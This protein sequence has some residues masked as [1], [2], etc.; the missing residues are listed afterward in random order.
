M[1]IHPRTLIKKCLKKK[2]TKTIIKNRKTTKIGHFLGGP[3]GSNERGLRDIFSLWTPLW[4]KMAPD[5]P[6]EPPNLDFQRFWVP[7]G[8]LFWHFFIVFGLFFFQELT[9]NNQ[10]TRT[11]NQEHWAENEE[12][13]KND[14][15]WTK[16]KEQRTNNQETRAKNQ[17]RRTKNK[18][19]RTKNTEQRTQNKEHR[20]KNPGTVAGMARRAVGYTLS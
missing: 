2:N 4:S 14:E 15:Q 3:R 19:Q 1:K 17:E 6:P 18:A 10:E 9:T 7:P 13:R 16:N 11:K 20:T 8:S 5:L 12:Q